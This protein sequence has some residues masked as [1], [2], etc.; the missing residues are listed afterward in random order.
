VRADLERELGWLGLRLHW[1]DAR[2]LG[3][4]GYFA[5]KAV[6]AFGCVQIDFGTTRRLASGLT[7]LVGRLAGADR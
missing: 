6:A 1:P 4:P 2:P 7:R 3:L 5:L